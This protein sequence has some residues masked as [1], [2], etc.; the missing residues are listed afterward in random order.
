LI[1]AP[2]LRII[3]G[4]SKS[5]ELAMVDERKAL[6]KPG[7]SP[8]RIGALIAGACF[9]PVIFAIAAFLVAPRAMAG[10]ILHAALAILGLG[11]AAFTVEAAG[12]SGLSVSHIVIGE[13]TMISAAWATLH[14][15]KLGLLSGIHDGAIDGLD[16]RVAPGGGVSPSSGPARVPLTR[17]RFPLTVRGLHV[18]IATPGL[19]FTAVSEGPVLLHDGIAGR[20]ALA[21]LPSGEGLLPH[22]GSAVFA[23]GQTA[24]LLQLH[25]APRAGAS[26]VGAHVSLD[27]TMTASARG[28]PTRL[29]LALRDGDF[30]GIG[31]SLKSL[32]L[33][34]DMAASG[35]GAALSLAGC[36][37]LAGLSLNG[38][39]MNADRLK[40]CPLPTPAVSVKGNAFGLALAVTEAQIR[41]LAKR[42]TPFLSGTLPTLSITADGDLGFAH[43]R[44]T[45]KADGGALAGPVAL[46][47][48]AVALNAEAEAEQGRLTRAQFD[49]TRAMLTGAQ[50]KPWLAPVTL[51]GRGETR[52]GQIHFAFDGAGGGYA[53]LL[54]AEGT[55]DLQGSTG[56][57][58]FTLTP[59][60]FG[61]A[62]HVPEALFPSLAGQVS[63]ARGRFSAEGNY[64]WG[65]QGTRSAGTIR[66]DNLAARLPQGKIEGVSGTLALSGLAPLATATPQVLRISRLDLGLPLTDGLLRFSVD[67]T[68][69]VR[70]HEGH[71]AW[72][73]GTV[74]ISEATLSLTGKR[75]LVTFAIDGIDLEQLLVLAKVKGLSGTGRLS[76]RIPV[77]IEGGHQT[78]SAGQLYADPLGGTLAY[79][80]GQASANPTNPSALLYTAL[81]DFHYETLTGELSGDLAGTLSLR[82][83]LK[84]RNPSLYDGRKVELN[85]S[86]EGPFV[87]MVRKGLYGYRTGP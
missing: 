70:I 6:D 16:I 54:H 35:E 5:P 34:G 68:G 27:L 3:A 25:L 83:H 77:T 18:E 82:V 26:G 13:G 52:D 1:L 14:F 62:G 45:L 2:R 75:Q 19:T 73:G 31:A 67:P 48:S 24:P 38:G 47:L 80:T 11:P 29:V 76:G 51:T 84:G 12:W 53:K 58:Q 49:L 56:Q 64:G 71:L 10:L 28:G 33:A 7:R 9:S 39:R 86:T 22:E 44:A 85:V 65:G 61:P 50:P 78:V 60:D 74:G 41:I 66:F 55:T 42:G 63:E 20:L 46:T 23:D 21:F 30:P 8:R 87:D 15:G 69:A 4:A 37:T 59:L 79:K 57:A 72:L 32:D 17:I 40:L 81:D 36:G 43:A